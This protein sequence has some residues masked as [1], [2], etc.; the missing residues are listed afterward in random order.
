MVMEIEHYHCF[1]RDKHVFCH[2]K[3]VCHNKTNI[4]SRQKY[5]CRDKT[6][7]ATKFNKFATTKY[8]YDK[9]CRDSIYTVR[10]AEQFFGLGKVSLFCCGKIMV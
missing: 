8:F 4:L 7:V 2:N 3:C 1:C 10:V 9:T 6:F 5:A